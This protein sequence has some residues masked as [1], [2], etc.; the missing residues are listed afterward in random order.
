MVPS[1]G[2]TNRLHLILR[3][4]LIDP[5]AEL[6]EVEGAAFL[7]SKEGAATLLDVS[8]IEGEKLFL[9]SFEAALVRERVSIALYTALV[10]AQTAQTDIGPEFKFLKISGNPA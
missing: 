1:L 8:N 9:G 5:G 2:L 7:S 10:Q 4:S 6:V 3:T